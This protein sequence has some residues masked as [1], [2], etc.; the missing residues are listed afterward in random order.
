MG[1]KYY[2]YL[3]LC[4]F[5][6]KSRKRH[7]RKEVKQWPGKESE[8]VP[9]AEGLT[10]ED[11]KAANKMMNLFNLRLHAK[12]QTDAPFPP[13]NHHSFGFRIPQSQSIP[14]PPLQLISISHHPALSSFFIFFPHSHSYLTVSNYYCHIWLLTENLPKIDGI[15][16]RC[17][18]GEVSISYGVYMF[19]RP[20]LFNS[21]ITSSPPFLIVVQGIQSFSF[22]F[23]FSLL[24]FSPFQF[25]SLTGIGNLI[26][27]FG[28]GLGISLMMLAN[29]EPVCQCGICS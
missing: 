13:L 24:F 2:W 8:K 26:G 21:S 23:F 3:V 19:S 29:S 18:P 11:G 16:A 5:V 10:W 15:N 6:P 28:I 17:S 20:L 7:N 14:F 12:A 4:V 22:T 27:R 9:G 25:H 1:K